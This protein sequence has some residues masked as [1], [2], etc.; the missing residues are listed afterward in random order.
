MGGSTLFY[1]DTDPAARNVVTVKLST[2]G[3]SFVVTDT[4]RSNS[5]AIQMTSDGSCTIS[6][7]T[8]TCPAGAVTSLDIETGDQDDTVT[9]AVPTPARLL[10]G[11]G[12]DHLTGGSG[13]ESTK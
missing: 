9:V 6:R 11:T 12:N 7:G 2:D 3:K 1:V 10:G 4:G 13:E 8:G 5:K